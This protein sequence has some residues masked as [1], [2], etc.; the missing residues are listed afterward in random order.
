MP[1][2]AGVRYAAATVDTSC[3]PGGEPDGLHRPR[4]SP[5][6]YPSG[7]RDRPVEAILRPVGYPKSP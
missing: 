2:C 6:P 7:D 4:F 5:Y 1:G 3:Q